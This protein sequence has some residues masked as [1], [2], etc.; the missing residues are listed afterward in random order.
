MGT[1]SARAL[2]VD[3]EPAVRFYL[4]ET[5]RQAGHLVTTASNGE[6]ALEQLLGDPFDLIVLDLM[7]GGRIDGQ[8]VLEAVRWRWPGT[9]VVILTAHGSLVS[10]MEAIREGIDGFL[11]KPVETRELLHTVA[12]AL[13]RRERLDQEAT[14]QRSNLLECGPFC[15]DLA[16]QEL[17]RDGEPL[18][19]TLS[20][21]R[22]FSYLMWHPDEI[23]PPQE[24][25]EAVRQYKCDDPEE[26]SQV[27]KWYIYRLR[28]KIEPDPSRPQHILNVR[29]MGY[30]LVPGRP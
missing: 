17:T 26:A 9:V 3:D 5:L 20:E 24:L 7:L 13:R 2:V 25:V 16:T 30:R 4:Q 6:E 10:A 11:L 27:I 28:R 23:V 18:Q 15:L 19:L 21:F 14:V 8:R 1:T 12:E 22:L 29:G